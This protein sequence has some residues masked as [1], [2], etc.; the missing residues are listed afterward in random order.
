MK[1]GLSLVFFVVLKILDG[2]VNQEHV[3]IKDAAKV[4]KIIKDMIEGGPHALQVRFLSS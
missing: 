4:L 3:K 2:L 1:K